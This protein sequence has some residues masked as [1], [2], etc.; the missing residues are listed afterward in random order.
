MAGELRPPAKRPGD[1]PRCPACGGLR[2]TRCPICRT[3]GTDCAEA[4]PD[5]V[6]MVDVDQGA[7]P[8][9]CGCGSGGCTAGAGGGESPEQPEFPAEPPPRMLLCPTCDDPFVPEYARRCDSC[10]HEYTDGYDPE[11]ERNADE[12]ISARAIAATLALVALL[13]AIVIYFALIL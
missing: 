5:F 7:E 2:I 1:W 8:T 10:G 3:A 11:P 4:D 9:S 12:R 6:G 13:I